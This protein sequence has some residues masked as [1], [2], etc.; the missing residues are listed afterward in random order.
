MINPKRAG[1]IGWFIHNPVAANLL[2]ILVIVLGLVAAGDLRKEA[3]PRGMVN[4]VTVNISYDSGSAKQSEEGLA[5]KIEQ[6]LRG[7]AGIEN[8][9]SQSTRSGVSVEVEMQSGYDIDTLFQEVKTQI[10][11]ISTFPVD[12]KNPVIDMGDGDEHAIWIQ[13]YG[14]TDRQSLQ[15]IATQ[16]ERDLLSKPA[17]HRVT[18]SGWRD[19]MMMIEIDDGRLQSYGLTLSDVEAAI[20]N[21]SSNPLTAVL[22]NETI[23]LQL[24]AAEQAYLK[25]DF[26]TI[27][28]ITGNN[29]QQVYLGDVADILDSF[30]DDVAVLSRF[31]G[32]NSI[33]LQVVTSALNDIGDSVK[34]ATDV[35]E[36]WRNE[37][38]LPAGIEMATWHDRSVNITDRLQILINNAIIGMVLVF[39]L[40]ALFLNLSVAFWVAMGLP[41]VFLGTLFFMGDNWANLTLN[42]F[43]TFGFLMALGIIVDDAVVI[44]ESI[45]SVRSR[46]GDTIRSTIKGTMQV[47]MPTIFGV[48]TTVVAFFAMSQIEGRLG[49]I[50]AQFATVVAIALML[51]LIES[52]LILPAHL[53][54]LNTQKKPRQNPLSRIFRLL[55]DAADNSLQ[56]FSAHVYLPVLTFCLRFRYAMVTV[57]IMVFIIVF[58]MP[59]NGTIRM[60]FFPSI[61]GDTVRAQISMHNDV[62]YGRTHDTLLLLEQTAYQADR[63]LRDDNESSGI[64]NLQ[65][66]SEADHRGSITVELKPDA[67]YNMFA[68]RQAWE[69]QSGL[70]EGVRSLRIQSGRPDDDAL[71]IELRS[72]DDRVLELAGEEISALLEPMP[73][74]IGLQNNLQPGQP[75]LQLK[76]NPQGEA[77]GL[78]TDQLAIQIL[79]GFSGQVVQRY[80]RN[81][82]EIEVKVR[83]PEADRQNPADVLQSRVRLPDGS[84]IPLASVA[85]VSYGFTRDSITRINGQRAVYLSADV[86]KDSLSVTE[87]VDRLEHNEVPRLKAKYPDLDIYFAGEAE[88]QRETEASMIHLFLLAMLAIYALLAIPLKSYIQPIIIMTAIP[89]GIVGALLGHWVN[90]LSLGILSMNGIIALSGVVV[91]D[92][93]LLAAR[94]NEI[95]RESREITKA[96]V[97][98]GRDRIRAVLLT[99]FTTFAGLMPLLWETSQTA[100]FLVPAAVSL[101]Y[102]VMFAT[103]ITLLLIPMLLM[104]EH[105]I[106]SRLPGRRDLSIP[107]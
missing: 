30:D 57:F 19:P 40:L 74:I 45:Y 31:Q 107:A 62:S 13:L 2:M 92:S 101:A 42:S 86:D 91:N 54:H 99:S 1:I 65:V 94:F 93:L 98:A 84:V 59:F 34:Q 16:I 106:R 49:E 66:I 87:L 36:V 100:F 26:A 79:Q 80:Q 95:K 78:T 83:Y 37:Q 58:S 32:Q 14:D 27:P 89:F 8:I 81:S 50:Y 51:S 88:E 76:L 68:F 55:Q 104:I 25:Q 18:L 102:G 35:V 90:D 3:F 15:Q 12:A 75:Q 4:E 103:I 5:I 105:D 10:D 82:D 67:P 52:K 39:V 21:N 47:A 85:E 17:I 38:K 29:G 24:K 33:G 11:A 46:E 48:F 72:N 9:I 69:K 63:Q 23:Y 43:T 60:S 73:G 77:M 41:F 22:R 61:P 20:N 64:G 28:L 56:W 7:V 97:K 71:R 53:T 96:V 6:R 70:P 44:G